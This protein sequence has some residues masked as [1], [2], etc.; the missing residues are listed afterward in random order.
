MEL[1]GAALTVALLIAVACTNDEL[2]PADSGPG[3]GGSA[4]GAA[5][6]TANT[7]GTTAAGTSGSAGGAQAGASSA[8]G[9]VQAG[10]SGVAG[11]SVRGSAGAAGSTAREAGGAAGTAGAGGAPSCGPL[12]GGES[13][14]QGGSAGLAITGHYT[15]DFGGTHVITEDTWTQFGVFEITRFSNEEGWIVARNSAENE[16]NPC[17]WSRF[18]FV[19][20]GSEL[21]FCQGTYDAV[22]EAEALAAQPADASDPTVGGCGNYP[23]SRLT[24][25]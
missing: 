10:T 20:F 5:N 25:L 21:Y 1:G 2:L 19:F 15:D 23:W 7:A 12:R 6:L 22:S 14:G 11:G 18:D 16:Y 13:G 17:L 24:P 9:A 8:A 3:E 4:A